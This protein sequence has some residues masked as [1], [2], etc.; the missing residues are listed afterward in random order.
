VAGASRHNR[1]LGRLCPARDSHTLGPVLFRPVFLRRGCGAA[2][3]EEAEDGHEPAEDVEGVLQQRLVD[4]K[5]DGDQ[6][7]GD[8]GGVAQGPSCAVL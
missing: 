8:A 4:L 7:R 2:A 6:Q 5:A 1:G 3:E